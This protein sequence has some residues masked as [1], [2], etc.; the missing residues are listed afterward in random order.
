MTVKIDL[1]GTKEITEKYCDTFGKTSKIYSLDFADSTSAS[2]E[3]PI[4]GMC[5]GISKYK[6]KY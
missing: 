5:E 1:D 6:R 3:F 2:R 4:F